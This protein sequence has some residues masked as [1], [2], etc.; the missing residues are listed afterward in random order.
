[1]AQRTTYP[2]ESPRTS[3]QVLH[4]HFTG[5][6]AANGT[7]DAQ[8]ALNGEIVS[9]TWS[10]TG[11]YALVF[12]HAYPELKGAPICSF[13]A[14]TGGLD[15]QCSA[16]DVTAKTATLKIYAGTTLT[17]LTTNDTV[18]LTWAVRNSGKNK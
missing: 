17:D 2:I 5:A 3:V 7:L 16:I 10:S 14:T 8:E 18:Y 12:R 11:V 4:A 9:A 15:G 13:I 1:M 6:G